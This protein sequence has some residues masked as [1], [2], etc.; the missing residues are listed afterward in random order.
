MSKE[1]Q[2]NNL[3]TTK[4]QQQQKPKKQKKK[5]NKKQNKTPKHQTCWLF[6]KLLD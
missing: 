1:N 5:K 6:T 2:I 3:P 4:Q